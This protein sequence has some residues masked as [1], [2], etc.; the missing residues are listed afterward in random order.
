MIV[1]PS[2]NVILSIWLF[3][4]HYTRDPA[5]IAGSM[6]AFTSMSVGVVML[7]RTAP[8]T[9]QARPFT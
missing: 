4:E 6:V 3:K 5:K 9:M 8:P 1:D 2:V 7:T